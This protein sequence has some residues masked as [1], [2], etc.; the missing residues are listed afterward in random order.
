MHHRIRSADKLLLAK[1]LN[2]EEGALNAEEGALTTEECFNMGFETWT[3]AYATPTVALSLSPSLSLSLS[4]SNTHTHTHR[5]QGGAGSWRA[6]L[7]DSQQT[8]KRNKSWAS[9]RA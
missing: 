5:D 4:L 9:F 1:A 6:F 7:S 3:V 8:R 2:A